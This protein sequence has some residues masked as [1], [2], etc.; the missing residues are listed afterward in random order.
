M[1]HNYE[2]DLALLMALVPSAA[3]YIGVL[4]SRKRTQELLAEMAKRCAKPTKT[5]LAKVHAPVGLDVGGETP[6]EVA[7]SIVAEIQAVFAGRHGGA[8]RG[9]KGPIHDRP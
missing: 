2:R 3:R 6:A 5:Q 7:L 9:R 4:G 8:L 1:S